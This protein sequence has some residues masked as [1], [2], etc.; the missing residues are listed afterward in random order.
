MSMSQMRSSSSASFVEEI[1]VKKLA[2]WSTMAHPVLLLSRGG[3]G[4]RVRN[5]VCVS[6]C[7]LLS[8]ER[9]YS[10][11]PLRVSLFVPCAGKKI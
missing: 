10:V 8:C 7:S 5:G 2:T 1:L 11:V 4:W 9:L 3:K 6:E